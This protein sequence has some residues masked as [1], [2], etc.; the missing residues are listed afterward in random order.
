MP[1]GTVHLRPD[2]VSAEAACGVFGHH[3][4]SG[5]AADGAVCAERAGGVRLVRGPA[6]RRRCHQGGRQHAGDDPGEW[7]RVNVSRI[8]YGKL[9]AAAS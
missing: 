9:V 6:Q 2:R 1:T 4:A 3:R 8:G 5:G 7:T